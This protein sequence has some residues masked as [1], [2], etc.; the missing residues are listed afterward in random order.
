M[1]SAV[2]R[3]V[4]EGLDEKRVGTP[5][6][7]GL[8][9]WPLLDSHFYPQ[10]LLA[11]NSLPRVMH[12]PDGDNAIPPGGVHRPWLL[13]PEEQTRLGTAVG[14]GGPG[15]PSSVDMVVLDEEKR[16][17]LFEGIAEV[18]DRA[19]IGAWSRIGIGIGIGLGNGSKRGED[20]D[21]DEW[22]VVDLGVV[23][24]LRE[25][26]RRGAARAK[27]SREKKEKGGSGGRRGRGEKIHVSDSEPELADLRHE[28]GTTVNR[29][30]GLIEAAGHEAIRDFM[31]AYKQD[32]TYVGIASPERW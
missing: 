1:T 30:I 13:S 20:E 3:A 2:L 5:D 29:A 6:G 11:R 18:L 14:V 28:T 31:R 4:A 8:H 32:F 19:V 17:V 15:M 26:A 25:V 12:E 10:H 24:H 7:A 9:P 16:E 21:N 27:A 22:D 23:R